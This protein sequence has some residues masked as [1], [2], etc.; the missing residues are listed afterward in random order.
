[1]QPAARA[2]GS[3][4]VAHDR[5]PIC[6]EEPA[7]LNAV[8]KVGSVEYATAVETLR[9]L[10]AVH[11][12]LANVIGP[13][14]YRGEFGP[15][16][17]TQMLEIFGRA[18][19]TILSKEEVAETQGR[20]TLTM[21][22]SPDV[23]GCRPWSVSLTLKQDVALTRAPNLV[24]HATTWSTSRRENQDDPEFDPDDAVEGVLVA[25]AQAYTE[26]NRVGHDEANAAQ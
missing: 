18:G 20:P 9:G 25:F 1:M 19:I 15:A 11:I 5:L 3:A 8:P 13:P 12:D 23:A 16:A 26:A 6:W 24:I 4:D 21:R 10:E 2:L 7:T 14:W 17:Q 22:Y